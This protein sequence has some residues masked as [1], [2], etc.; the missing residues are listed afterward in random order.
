MS[1]APPT[2]WEVTVGPTGHLPGG[3][4]IAPAAALFA[5]PLHMLPEGQVGLREQ[6]S[7]PTPALSS[8]QRWGYCVSTVTRPTMSEVGDGGAITDHRGVELRPRW[9]PGLRGHQSQYHALSPRVLGEFWVYQ[10]NAVRQS[11]HV[12][13]KIGG[14]GRLLGPKCRNSP[15]VH[16]RHVHTRGCLVVCNGNIYLSLRICMCIQSTCAHALKQPRCPSVQRTW[17]CH[18]AGTS[19]VTAYH[20]RDGRDPGD[21][22]A[23]LGYSGAS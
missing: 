13:K 9:T 21:E 14:Q 3:V 11:G 18:V 5:V 1:C 6:A 2:V 22:S 19:Q 16:R 4:S 7:V 12:V 15:P 23:E 8:P 10:Q 20:F 17:H